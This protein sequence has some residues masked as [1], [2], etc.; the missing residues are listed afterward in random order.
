MS[1]FLRLF[2]K[3]WLSR[4]PYYKGFPP[5]FPCS[6]VCLMVGKSFCICTSPDLFH[7]ARYHIFPS[8]YRK[9]PQLH[10]FLTVVFNCVNVPLFLYSVILGGALELLPVSGIMNSAVMNIDVQ[11]MFP[12]AVFEFRKHSHTSG[13]A[14]S[15]RSSISSFLKNI[16]IFFQK[17]W[18]S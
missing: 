2:T 8:I 10:F 7:L 16:Y 1:F 17:G 14:E 15:N 11:M 4:N 6:T 12:L 3:Q 18:T 13:I 5:D 9:V